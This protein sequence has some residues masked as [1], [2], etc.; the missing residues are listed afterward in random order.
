MPA[1]QRAEL[2]VQRRVRVDGTGRDQRL[3]DLARTGRRDRRRVQRLA[4]VIRVR[5]RA[6]ARHAAQ[7]RCPARPLGEPARGAAGIRAEER[8]ARGGG[9]PP[10]RASRARLECVLVAASR[11]VPDG[12]HPSR[13]GRRCRDRDVHPSGDRRRARSARRAGA[14][15]DS[16]RRSP[17]ARREGQA[18]ARRP[19]RNEV[20]RQAQGGG[21]RRPAALAHDRPRTAPG[22]ASPARARRAARSPEPARAPTG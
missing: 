3:A 10:P 17:C 5:R 21:R 8:R 6:H 20:R 13:A 11:V 19:R 22:E 2:R 9:A 4:G 7:R 18:H 1:A 15:A 12:L 16:R 14:G